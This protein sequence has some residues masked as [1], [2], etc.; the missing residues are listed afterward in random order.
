MKEKIS[1]RPFCALLV[2]IL[3]GCSAIEVRSP[4]VIHT[5][6]ATHENKEAVASPEQ[7]PT[8]ESTSPEEIKTSASPADIQVLSDSDVRATSLSSLGRVTVKSD[9]KKGFT[10]AQAVQELK[11]MAF[12]RYGS[13]AQGLA[14]IEYMD[15]P[16]FFDS[17]QNTFRQASAEVFTTSSTKQQTVLEGKSSLET[18]ETIPPL[19]NI[20]IVSSAELFNL[21]FKILGVVRA[22][23]AS[24]QGMTEEQA[25]KTL[26][27]E[28][29]RLYGTRA[30]ALTNIK[31][32]KEY[33][34]YYYK[35]PQ[36]SPPPK[37]PEGYGKATAEVVYW[38]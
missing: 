21:N 24:P 8:S 34:I 25:V 1:I 10:P 6:S 28:A 17:S 37:A 26:K 33:P 38:P 7:S 30:K 13:L 29:Y 31:M 32:K 16:G 12:K 22:R 23:D 18:H 35:K 5:Q 14:H 36:Y 15:R 19:E 3:S 4:I 27:I 2:I 11:I 20:A 9:D